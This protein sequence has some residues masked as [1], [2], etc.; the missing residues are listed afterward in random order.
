MTP[1]TL[2]PL[3]AAAGLLVSTGCKPLFDIRKAMYDQQKYEPLE[4]TDFF[5]DSR[6]ARPLVA[7]T[8]AQGQL[9]LNDHLYLGVEEIDGDF[10]QAVSYPFE[11]TLADLERGRERYNIYCSVCHGLSGNGEGMVVRRGYKAAPVFHSDKLRNAPPGYFFGVITGG[12]GTMQSYAHQIPVEDRW[13][14]AAYVKTLQRSQFASAEDLAKAEALAAA[15][16][17]DKPASTEHANE[18]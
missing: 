1:R 4:A 17:A 11:I 7:D 15:A 14:I 5:G 3:L 6:S 16:P 13:R 9:R 12:F 8:V 10:K 18:H 2:L